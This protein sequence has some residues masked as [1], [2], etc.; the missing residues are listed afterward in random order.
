MSLWPKSLFEKSLELL[1]HLHVS[2]S[3]TMGHLS[4]CV[5]VPLVLVCVCA[6]KLIKL[7]LRCNWE[8][9]FDFDGNR[10][11]CRSEMF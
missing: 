7:W 2:G 6:C 11:R 10:R 1:A 5:C 8:A 3:K 9:T 4:V